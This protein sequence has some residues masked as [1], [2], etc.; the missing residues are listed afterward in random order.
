MYNNPHTPADRILYHL[1]R[2]GGVLVVVLVLL[3]HYVR[4]DELKRMRC[5]EEVW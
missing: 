1:V 5:S 4:Q 3:Y 2:A